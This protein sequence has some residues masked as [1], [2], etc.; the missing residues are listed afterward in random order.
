M[1]PGVTTEDLLNAPDIVQ[2]EDAP[3][4]QSAADAVRCKGCKGY[5]FSE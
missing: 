2:L 3:G 1:D 4:L 5:T